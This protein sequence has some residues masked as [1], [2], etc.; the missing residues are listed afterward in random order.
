MSEQEVIGQLTGYKRMRA[1]IKVLENYSV[2]AGITVSRLSEDDHLQELHRKL[3]GMPSYMYLSKR[4]QELETAAHAY[5][6]R[7]PAGTKSQLQAVSVQ[8]ADD[9][10]DRALQELRLKIKKVIDARAGSGEI[11]DYDAVLD[12]IT[13]LQQLRAEVEQIDRALEALAEYKPEYA[14]LLRMRYASGQTPQEVTDKLKIAPRTFRKRQ[15]K[16]VE[17]YKLL[18]SR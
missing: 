1:R 8:G 11:D 3:R 10:D 4:E 6:A 9:E 14:E 7:Y 2:G 17:E 18:Q 15:S 13:E 16:A 12:R 5:L